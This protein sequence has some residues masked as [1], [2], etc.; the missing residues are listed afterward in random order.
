MAMLFTYP[1]SLPVLVAASTWLLAEMIGGRS[2][3]PWFS[4]AVAFGGSFLGA[5]LVFLP[6]FFISA[7]SKVI[8]YPIVLGGPIVGVLL[9]LAIAKV[10]PKPLQH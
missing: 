9:A 8:S 2:S 6:Y 7:A 10:P 4:A 3:R 5:A 1:F